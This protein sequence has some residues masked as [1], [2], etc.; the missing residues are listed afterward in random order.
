[1]SYSQIGG[2]DYNW[3][4]Q[5]HRPVLDLRRYEAGVALRGAITFATRL[6]LGAAIGG[7]FGATTPHP[8]LWLATG[9]LVG[10]AFSRLRARS[11][12]R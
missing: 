4:S 3:I 6:L 9:A 10:C 11:P 2:F 12:R 8:I 5:T 1:M 7:A